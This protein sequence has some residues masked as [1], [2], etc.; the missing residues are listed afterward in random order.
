MNS[1][2]TALKKPIG[3]YILAL[4]FIFAPIGN[5]LISFAGSGVQNWY[6]PSVINAFLQSIPLWDWLWL[7]LLVLAGI[8]LFRPHKLSWSFAIFTLI[9]VLAIN[10]FRLYSTDNNSIDP[11]YLRVFSIVALLCTL[12]VL[13]IAFYFRFPYLDRR[14]DWVKNIERYDAVTDILIDGSHGQTESIS[15]TGCRL[16]L[17]Q[18]VKLNKGTHV[19]ALIPDVSKEAIACQVVESDGHILRLEFTKMSSDF[20]ECLKGWLKSRS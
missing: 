5:I 2:A 9:L 16:R 12:G 13:T 11:N 4:L 7:S 17:D 14:A 19:T 1:T 3:V 6:E 20:N 18:P 15:V 10:A 8:L